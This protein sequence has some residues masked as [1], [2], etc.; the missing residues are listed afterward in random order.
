MFP[1]PLPSLHISILIEQLIKADFYVMN[2]SV[3]LPDDIPEPL[4]TSCAKLLFRKMCDPTD[5]LLLKS[6]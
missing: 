4:S 2:Y 6:S 1:P 5:P 3:A